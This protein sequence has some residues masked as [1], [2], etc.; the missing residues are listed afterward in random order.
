MY[1]NNFVQDKWAIMVPKTSHPYKCWP[2][3][4]IFFKFCRV[5][6]ANRY[7]KIFLVVFLEKKFIWGNLIFL[8]LFLLFDWAWSKLSQVTVTIGSLNSQDII[9]FMNTTGSLNSPD[10]IR[11]RKQSRHDFSC[12]HVMDIVWILCDVYLWRSK[13]NR[14]SYCFVKLL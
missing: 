3:L 11:I 5:K 14:G 2:A 4:R 12:K 13:F 10:M 6:G 7:M 9:S 8:G 1:Q